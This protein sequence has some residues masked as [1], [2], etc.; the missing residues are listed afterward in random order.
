MNIAHRLSKLEA[1]DQYKDWECYSFIVHEDE[2]EEEVIRRHFGEE[3]PPE[4]AFI[5]LHIIVIPNSPRAASMGF[6]G[7]ERDDAAVVT[8]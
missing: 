8:D 2:T 3:G 1:V 4:N 5:I 7:N 6:P